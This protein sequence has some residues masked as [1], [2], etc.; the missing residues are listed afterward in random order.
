MSIEILTNAKEVRLSTKARVTVRGLPWGD[1]F[2]L[3]KHAGEAANE[4]FVATETGEVQ[5]DLSRL[6]ELLLQSSDLASMLLDG[7][8]DIAVE[9]I[10]TLPIEDVLALIDAALELT[11]TEGVQKNAAALGARLGG[12]FQQAKQR[13][14]QSTTSSPRGTAPKPY[15]GTRSD[16]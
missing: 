9:E 1:A 8:T 13:P 11:V 5:A 12:L 15:P 10:V 3:L 16:S 7:A 4:L 6:P 14:G 2:R